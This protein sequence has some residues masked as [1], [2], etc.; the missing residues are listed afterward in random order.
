MYLDF[1]DFT[2][3]NLNLSINDSPEREMKSINDYKEI[4]FN[5]NNDLDSFLPLITL[6]LINQ[7]GNNNNYYESPNFKSLIENLN[8]Y[9]TPK[10]KLEDL[11]PN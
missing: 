7:V 3:F 10:K 2:D 11:K 9:D 5:K 4:T 8:I 1:K 6:P